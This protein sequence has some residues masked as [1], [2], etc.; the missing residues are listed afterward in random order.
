MKFKIE[1]TSMNI[2]KYLDILKKYNLEKEEE[3][4][5]TINSLEEL[6]KLHKEIKQGIIIDTFFGNIELEIYD[7]YR[8]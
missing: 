2:D 4:F 5:I 1:A 7:T 3:Y 6:M 8:E